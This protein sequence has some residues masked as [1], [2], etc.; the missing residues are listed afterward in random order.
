MTLNLQYIQVIHF[1]KVHSAIEITSFLHEYCVHDSDI[2]STGPMPITSS[3]V[4][5]TVIGCSCSG[6]N[7]SNVHS[8][9]SWSDCVISI[10]HIPRNMQMVH[11]SSPDSK[12]YGANMGPTWARQDPGGPHVIPMNLAIWEEFHFGVEVVNMCQL[13]K[14]QKCV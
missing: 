6:F 12:V 7:T 5:Y 2:H 14:L 10:L 4:I 13:N 11:S 3:P 8:I 1:P 9:C